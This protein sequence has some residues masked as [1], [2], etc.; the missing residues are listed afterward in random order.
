MDNSTLN[1]KI[2]RRVYTLYLM[3][4]VFNPTAFRLYA[5]VISIIAIAS[6]VSISN[7]LANIPTDSLVSFYT[8]SMNAVLG[9]E[10]VVQLLILAMLASLFWIARDI[11][12]L[13]SHRTFPQHI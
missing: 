5:F 11:A 3:R 2:M 12:Y 10:L 6:F 13:L 1:Q 8:F 4:K 9:T 7:V